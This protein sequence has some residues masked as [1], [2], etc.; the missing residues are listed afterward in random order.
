M[1]RSMHIQLFHSPPV[2]VQDNGMREYSRHIKHVIITLNIFSQ[3]WSMTGI[4]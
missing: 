1:L 4:Y 3:E 2:R